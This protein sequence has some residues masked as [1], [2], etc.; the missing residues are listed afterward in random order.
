ML[1]RYLN[2][3]F[4]LANGDAS[5]LE[6]F[7]VM[8]QGEI[9]PGA[10]VADWCIPGGVRSICR[11]AIASRRVVGLGSGV[12]DLGLLPTAAEEA[13][14]FSSPPSKDG[15]PSESVTGPPL[16]QEDAASESGRR[17]DEASSRGSESECS[18]AQQA[19]R[20]PQPR[21]ESRGS[22]APSPRVPA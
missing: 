13:Q 17:E 6:A 22:Q 7:P 21:A 1:L 14:D 5:T 2:A 12:Q 11:R 9:V 20:T 15:G 10:L 4:V 16:A 8:Q 3:R 18:G 19:P